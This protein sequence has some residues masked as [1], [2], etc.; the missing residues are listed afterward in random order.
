M[1]RNQTSEYVNQ[2][3]FDNE[4]NIFHASWKVKVK[5]ILPLMNTLVSKLGK[6]KRGQ[7][8]LFKKFV[9]KD[10]QG[11]HKYV[12]PSKGARLQRE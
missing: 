9:F 7:K 5:G 8:R 12:S 11:L 10:C 3:K 6:A 1:K 2:N 4:Q